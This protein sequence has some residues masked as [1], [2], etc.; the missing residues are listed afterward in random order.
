MLRAHH[1]PSIQLV[2]IAYETAITGCV[3]GSLIFA[4]IVKVGFDTVKGNDVV[5][6]DD[7]DHFTFNI[8]AAFLDQRRPD[9]ISLERGR[10]NFKNLSVSAP[11]HVPNPRPRSIGM[12]A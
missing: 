6:F 10:P 1:F 11:E 8:R 9:L 5:L 2:C 4:R 12:P 3:K 7:I